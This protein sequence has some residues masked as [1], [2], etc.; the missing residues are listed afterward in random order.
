MKI[1]NTITKLIVITMAVAVAALAAADVKAQVG[2]GSVKFVSYASIGIVPGQKVRVSMSNPEESTG[3]ATLSFSFYL[4]HQTNSSS[5]TPLYKSEVI[6]VP[7]KE[8]RFSDVTREDLNTE[9]EPETRRAEVRVEVT[10]V[11]PAGNNPEDFP[12]SL[13]I[14]K[15]E[16]ESG[17][18]VQTDSKYRLIILA[19]KRSKQLNAPIGF[20]PGQMLRYSVFNPNEDG[21]QP[22]QVQAYTYDSYGN[23]LS[24]TAPVKLEPGQGHII[25][26]DRYDLPAAG[27]MKTKRL[28]V[29]TGIQVVLMDGSVRHVNLPVSMELVDKTTGT[30]MDGNY[31]YYTGTVSVSGDG[32]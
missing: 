3:N 20:I 17:N 2:D 12:C 31:V 22:V 9:G 5:S 14:I 19:A 29:R 21:S 13:E 1:R 27:D 8:F 6:K 15:D 10:I 30:T 26:I 11:A 4:A 23:L 28:Q 7:P 24:Q 16:V 18:A 32:F 25:V